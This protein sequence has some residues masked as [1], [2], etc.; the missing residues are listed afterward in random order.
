MGVYK[1]YC[2]QILVRA[3][4]CGGRVLL[5]GLVAFSCA[6]VG[7]VAQANT[8]PEFR[9]DE[10]LDSYCGRCHNDER[11]SGNWSLSMV[12]LDDI[13]RGHRLAEWEAML[14]VVERGEMPPPNRPQ[15]SESD[16]H[17]FIS[18]LETGLDT[19]AAANPNPGRATLRRLNRTEYSNAV[20][21]LLAVDVDI[22]ESL[23]AD[24]TGYGFDNI[25][26][27][28]SVSPT[29]MDRYIAVAGKI[30]RL[31]VGVAS[32][33]PYNSTYLLPKDGS[34]LNQG[35]PSY[36]RRMSSDLPL[37]SRGGGAFKYYAPHDGIYE[38]SAYLNSNT[39]NEVDR[40]EQNHVSMRLP[41][42]A[43]S[44]SIGMAFRK[45]LVL[46]ESVQTLRNSTDVV[47]LPTAPPS[48]LTLDF[49]V[50][51]ARV[52]K[53]MVPSYYMSPRFAQKNFPRDVLQIDVEG[54]Y[55]ASSP[56]DTPS[57]AKI[58]ACKPLLWPIGESYCAR[59][60]IAALARQAYRRELEPNDIERLMNV[61][62]QAQ[63][64]AGYEQGIAAAIQA[65]LVAPNFLFLYEQDPADTVAG[66][67]HRINDYE[68]AARL[69]LFLWSSLPDDELLGLAGA[70]KLREP[71]ILER[72]VA[73]ML[74]DDRAIA[75]Q[76]NF[77]GQWLYLRN[78]EFHRPDVVAFPE[79]DTPLRLAMQRESELFFGAVLRDNA[80]ILNF[81]QSDYT[82]L[83]ERLAEHYGID[84][85]NGPMFRKVSVADNPMRG[86]LLGQASILTVTSYGNHTSV[87]RR[88]KWIL[89]NLLAAPPP[90]PPP[91]IPA[92]KT[93]SAGKALN[94]REQLALHSEDPA[95]ASCHTK[96][97]PLGL[98]LEQYDAVG[99]FRTLDAGRAIDVSAAM[100]DG[101]VFEGLTG[102]QR[103]LM[104]R[105]SQF[106]SA[107]TQRLMT[108]GLGRGLEP[109]DQP[110][111]RTIVRAAA[112]DD[113]RI[114]RIIM[115]IITSEPFNYRSTPNYE[116]TARS[117]PTLDVTRPRRCSS[118]AV[119]GIDDTVCAS[120]IDS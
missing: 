74:A 64:A 96:M 23:P 115:G 37:D 33:E 83:N 80:S 47:P 116:E 58:F 84:G 14:R 98:A 52:G 28:L 38:I 43:G 7:G 16:L 100:P 65:I 112:Q 91:D 102:L 93:K 56:G 45:Q 75:L 85:V 35:V 99:K 51:G 109:S 9:P 94:A 106:A 24:D 62:R 73:R 4:A 44:H 67:V 29:L 22:R 6:A 61:Y 11:M 101:S 41:L 21:D 111:V 81:I 15:P 70:Q 103:V 110:K 26:D 12:E 92:L 71:E 76:T 3:M 50:D 20:R 97:D 8:G 79:F 60:N 104:A 17:Q 36:D 34:I 2:D 31:A 10:F 119:H 13:G 18:W 30:S 19:Y 5:F 86:G 72:Q 57:R 46:D 90:P 27:V 77:A 59:K 25:A 107:F 39:N 108:Y 95:C 113:Y 54:P 117:E 87:V 1:S 40:L 32:V 68:Y 78:L 48:L 82:F 88:G 55:A 66:E 120:G 42:T 105:K 63:A 114:G 118:L 69:A 89:D 53:T 49:I